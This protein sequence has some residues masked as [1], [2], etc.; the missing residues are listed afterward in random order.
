MVAH[1]SDQSRP[2]LS[3]R[4]ANRIR[5]ATYG[6]IQNLFVEEVQGQ[7]VVRGQASSHHIRQLALQGALELLSADRCRPIITVG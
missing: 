6:R 2:T 3:E 1:T 4:V 7:V 5:E